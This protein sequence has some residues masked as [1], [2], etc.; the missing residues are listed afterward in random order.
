MYT[1][2]NDNVQFIFNVSVSYDLMRVHVDYFKKKSK[3]KNV[4]FLE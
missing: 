3:S 2:Q 4:N 1:I